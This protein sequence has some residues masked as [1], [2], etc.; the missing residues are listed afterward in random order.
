MGRLEENKDY[1]VYRYGDRL[2]P[3]MDLKVEHSVRCEDTDISSLIAQG[4]E[5]L[6]AMR[7]KSAGDEQKAFDIVV[8]A[9]NQWEKQAALTQA[10]DRALEYLR[11]PEVS[12]TANQWQPNRRGGDWEEI[13]NRVYKMSARIGESTK[14][15]RETK[16]TETVSWDVSWDIYVQSPKKQH[17][18]GEKIAGQKDKHYKDRAAAEKYLEGRKKAY[19]HLFMEVSPPIPAEYAGHFTV[20]GTLLPGY[21]VEGRE[22]EKAEHAADV[23]DGG[24]SMQEKEKKPSVLGK[25]SSARPQ[26]RTPAALKAANKKKED[27]QI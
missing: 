20:N 17:G 1:R 12:H 5:N 21:T 22:P 26:E 13:S 24:I 25:L 15:N 10:I 2:T 23:P 27:M 18:Y 8:A 14:Y 19:A 9:A 11:T 4:R 3:G 16:E 6:Q 7:L